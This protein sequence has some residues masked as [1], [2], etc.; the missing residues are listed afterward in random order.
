MASPSTAPGAVDA[1]PTSA[2]APVITGT[3]LVKRWGTNT[4]LS[5]ADLS[6]GPGVTG[7]LGSN[8]AGKTTLIGM[9]LGLHRP[10]A[11]TL[12]VLDLDPSRAGPEVRAR[13]GYSPEHHRLP[14]DMR[15]NDFVAHVAQIHGLPK[16]AAIN[17]A[18]DALWHVGLGE[19]RFRPLGTM[20]TG[21]RQRA[22]LAQAIVHDPALVLLDEPTDGLDPL[23][24]DDMLDL[25]RRIGRD[26]GIH[27]VLSS[28]LLEEV[29]Q[30][31]DGVV[32]LRDGLVGASGSLEAVRGT[33]Q[34]V[35]V[36]LLGDPAQVAAV[37]DRLQSR[38]ATVEL[39]GLRHV[40]RPVDPAAQP[41]LLFDEVRDAIAANEVAVRRLQPHRATLEDVF[42]RGDGDASGAE[43]AASGASA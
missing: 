43:P 39:D 30:V 14:P 32:I 17:R 4:V 38:G 8:G 36:E 41:D 3:G 37:V 1:V 18:S 24:R 28:H 10:D 35:V 5:G 29:E 26:F 6:I 40:I 25:I 33:T 2:A 27:I 11:G 12:R 13:I 21:Q 42:L 7:L 23:Q 16:R 15:V 19:E 22:K 20:S 31:C 9:I 34:G